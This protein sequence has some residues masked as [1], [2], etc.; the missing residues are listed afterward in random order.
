MAAI[1][2]LTTGVVFLQGWTGTIS[3]GTIAVA[4]GTASLPG[5]TFASQLNM[6]IYRTDST[7]MVFTDDGGSH[8]V[9]FSGNNVTLS[10]NGSFIT[11]ST[12][13]TGTSVL[14]AA[15]SST[16]THAA[17]DAYGTTSTDGLVLS[18]TT[19]ATVGTTVQIS[20]RVRWRGTVWDTA[21]SETVDFFSEVLPVTAATPTGIWKLGYSLNAA[22]ATYPLQ[23]SSAGLLTLPNTTIDST[24]TTTTI[25]SPS[26][27]LVLNAGN[28]L[29]RT[30]GAFSIYNAKNTAGIGVAAIYGYGDTVAAT[31]VGTA[32]IATYTPTADGTFN[33]GANCLVTTSTTHSFSLDC[34]YTDESN[35][36]RTLVLPVAQL[37]GTFVTS[38]LITNVTGVGPYETPQMT[39][40]VKANTA[41]TIR[42]SAG[43]T[44]TGVVYN[45]RGFI[46]QVA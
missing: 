18:N 25:N 26:G 21:A 28:L 23:L 4:D 31:N 19:A 1:L 44:F 39:I 27:A 24:T 3:G 36:A 15:A 32:A 29:L 17:P 6:G 22:A 9:T 11:G 41:I 38:G 42:T 45:A 34:T 7:H 10:T 12:S 16:F 20:P 35:S 8:T 46:K 14:L 13:I 40:R 30:N 37:A 33:V 2:N 43:G 5:F